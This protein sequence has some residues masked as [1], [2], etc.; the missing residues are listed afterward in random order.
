M[1]VVVLV[2]VLPPVVLVLVLA[3]ATLLAAVAAGLFLLLTAGLPL[4]ALRVLAAGARWQWHHTVEVWWL[5]HLLMPLVL[6]SMMVA[7][8]AL[9][10]CLCH[11]L[12]HC[13]PRPWPQ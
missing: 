4:V 1:V 6:M 10:P 5:V 2:L 9:R 7:A 3:V 12:C 13:C 8:V 11:R